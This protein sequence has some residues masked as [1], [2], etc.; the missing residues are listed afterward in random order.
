MEF[1]DDGGT[2]R[3][4]RGTL[5][6]TDGKGSVTIAA[7]DGDVLVARERIVL[8]KQGVAFGGR[9]RKSP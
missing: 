5:S 8:M 6:G 9:K 4:L 7:G 2:V 1:R 3:E